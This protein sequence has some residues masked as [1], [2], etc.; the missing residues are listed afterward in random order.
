MAA[1]N[2]KK[3]LASRSS[4]AAPSSSMSKPRRQRYES[5]GI[6]QKAASCEHKRW[7]A[8]DV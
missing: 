3:S 7:V 6:G 5:A 1:G 4:K 8:Q 2:A